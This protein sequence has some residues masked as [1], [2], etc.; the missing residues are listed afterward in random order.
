MRTF[1]E[2]IGEISRFDRPATAAAIH[3]GLLTFPARLLADLPVPVRLDVLDRAGRALSIATSADEA[4]ALRARGV[5]VLDRTEWTALVVA[6]ESD[7]VFADDLE[8]LLGLRGPGAITPEAA[9]SGAQPDAPRG[10]SVLTV[11]ARLGLRVRSDAAGGP[12]AN[13]EPPAGGDLAR[14]A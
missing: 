6:A 11:L 10:W 14:A 3:A 5:T 4:A 1:E 2:N 9:L 7:R 12:S 13:H 8:I